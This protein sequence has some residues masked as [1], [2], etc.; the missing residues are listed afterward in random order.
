MIARSQLAAI[1]F[2]LCSELT[3]AETKSGVKRFNVTYSKATNNWSAKPI[4]EKKNR[5][6][7]ENLISRVDGQRQ[8]AANGQR[9]PKPML[10]ILPK[11]I[12]SVEKPCKSTVI[13]NQ[14][15]RFR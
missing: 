8:V 10:P 6:V 1:D 13:A 11:T 2:N 7:F 14:R 9:L 15:S 12:A 5:S 4:K 3:Q